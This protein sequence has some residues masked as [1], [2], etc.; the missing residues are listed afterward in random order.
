MEMEKSIDVGELIN[1]ALKGLRLG[2]DELKAL[3]KAGIREYLT[4]Q[5]AKYE[6]VNTFLH[7]GD[8]VRFEEIYYPLKIANGK[9]STNLKNP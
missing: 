5:M 8:K 1:M 6:Y 4:T 9:N 2:S 7:R 3:S